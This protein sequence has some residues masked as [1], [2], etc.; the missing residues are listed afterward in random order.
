MR[1]T[2]AS[3]SSGAG[4]PTCTLLQLP[5]SPS[6]GGLTAAGVVKVALVLRRR[7]RFFSSFFD[8]SLAWR[9]RLDEDFFIRCRLRRRRRSV[10]D[11][12]ELES[13]E[14]LDESDSEE[15]VDGE[16]RLRRRFGSIGP[17]FRSKIKLCPTTGGPQV[18]KK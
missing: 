11:S 8:F 10:D 1:R 18:L 17:S 7:F 6:A 5:D 3:A 14:E 4:G 9:A 15:E 13:D 12:D 2:G 16:R